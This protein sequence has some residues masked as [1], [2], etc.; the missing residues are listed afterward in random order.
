MLHLHQLLLLECPEKLRF[1]QVRRTR[2]ISCHKRVLDR[3]LDQSLPGIPRARSP[4]QRRKLLCA[5]MRLQALLQQPLKQVVKA[6]PSMALVEGNQKQ[7]RV[8]QP[9]QSGLYLLARVIISHDHDTQLGAELL[10]HRYSLKQFLL[11]RRL[12]AEDFLHQ[13][14][15]YRAVG[16]ATKPFY[17]RRTVRGTAQ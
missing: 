9:V 10:Q 3:L 16:I 2:H 11:G 13:V 7:V 5:A 17:E 15:T 1:H 4:V 14:T 6:I 8:H 12:L